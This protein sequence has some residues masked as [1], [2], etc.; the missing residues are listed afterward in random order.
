MKRILFVDDEP[1]VLE[2]LERML[3]AQR[4]Q[5]EMSF[6]ASGAEALALLETRPF[7][8]IVTDVRMPEMGGVRLL[9]CVQQRFPATMRVVLSG[10]FER[11]AALKAAG[12]AHQYL[13]KPCDPERLCEAVERLCRLGPVFSDEATRRV[14]A[15][16]GRLPSPGRTDAGLIEALGKPDVP[17]E[18]VDRILRQDEGMSA[19]VLDLVNSAGFG[20]FCEFASLYQAAGPVELEPLSHLWLAVEIFRTFQ[21]DCSIAGFSPEGVRRHS[22]RAARIAARL[23]VPRETFAEAVTAALLHDVGKLVL[24]VRLPGPLERALETAAR[25]NR[26]QC[27]VEQEILGTDHAEV[28]GFLLSVWGLPRT[29]V[30]AV[31]RHHHPAAEGPLLDGLDVLA[32]AHTANAL[33]AERSAGADPWDSEYLAALGVA[34]RLPAWRAMAEQIASAGGI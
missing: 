31:T 9:E 32:V 7:D 18:E 6:V 24:A 5:W 27:A 2:G 34:D 29:I 16:V 11:E 19:R 3:H 15:A 21:P 10:F 30:D 14:V 28:G 1:K 4:K 22:R 8:A 26:P 23:P 13:A 12:L 25:E 33:D 20:L 17:L